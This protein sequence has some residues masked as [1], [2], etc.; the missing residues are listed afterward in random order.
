[1]I[2]FTERVQSAQVLSDYFFEHFSK[3][4]K[5]SE[6][7]SRSSLKD[8]ALSYLE[9]LP[10]GAFR[11]M[12][13]DKLSG[14]AKQDIEYNKA[15]LTQKKQIKKHQHDSGLS[16]P[17]KVIALLLQNPKFIEIVEQKEIDLESIGL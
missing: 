17:R 6:M 2:N 14:L 5:L 13:I 7:E 8:E 15:T 9:Q 3:D 10:I 11:E 1:M 16:L 4:L 12:M